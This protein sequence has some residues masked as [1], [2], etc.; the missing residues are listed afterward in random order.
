MLCKPFLLSWCNI[1][2]RSLKTFYN[3]LNIKY[4]NFICTNIFKMCPLSRCFA[5]IIIIPGK[6]RLS[7]LGSAV[8]ESLRQSRLYALYRPAGR[9]KKF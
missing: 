4:N 8:T 3:G 2:L 1:D 6:N 9:K 5:V 7:V